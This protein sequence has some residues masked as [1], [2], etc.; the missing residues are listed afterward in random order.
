MSN[1]AEAIV[2]EIKSRFEAAKAANSAL[3][4]VGGYAAGHALGYHDALG[5]L[6]E[7]LE[8][9]SEQRH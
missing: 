6:L 1:D 3:R 5:E 4:E 7:Y 2:N 9:C 8:E